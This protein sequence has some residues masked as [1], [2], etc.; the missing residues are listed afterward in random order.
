MSGLAESVD[1][2]TVMVAD[3][4]F[5]DYPDF[6]DAYVSEAYTVTGRALSDGECDELKDIH[7]EKVWDRIMDIYF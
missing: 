2:A 5:R 1:W 3:V 4:D 7:P 6:C